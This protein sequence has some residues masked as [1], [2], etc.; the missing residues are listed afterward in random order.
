MSATKTSTPPTITK[1]TAGGGAFLFLSF[2]GALVYFWSRADSAGDKILAILQ[3]IVW[4]A[5]LIY[6]ALR[7][8]LG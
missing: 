2:I 8:L 7:T 6:G 5:Y 1:T 4:P 3:A